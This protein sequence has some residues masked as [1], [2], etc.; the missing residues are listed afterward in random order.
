MSSKL[1]LKYVMNSASSR[2]AGRTLSSV[3][4]LMKLLLPAPV[5]PL[6]AKTAGPG[7]GTSDKRPTIY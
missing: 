5:Y 7:G 2:V 6:M 4:A 3:T 1:R